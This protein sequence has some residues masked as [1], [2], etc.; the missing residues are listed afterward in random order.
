M[1]ASSFSRSEAVVFASSGSA[2]SETDAGASG[3]ESGTDTDFSGAASVSVFETD[4]ACSG[5]ALAWKSGT[6][7]DF[8]GVGSVAGVE[9]WKSVS[10]PDFASVADFASGL[11][12]LA[13]KAE[14]LLFELFCLVAQLGGSFEVE[15][16]RSLAHQAAEAGDFGL[17]VALVVLRALFG[18]LGDRVVVELG[19]A[20]ERIVDC[21]DRA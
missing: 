13:A 14:L 8:A 4:A 9:F 1:R 6:D 15:A 21:A 11:S 16:L 19:H 7:T 5:E 10:V 2:G 20:H 3:G 17:R 18:H 12:S